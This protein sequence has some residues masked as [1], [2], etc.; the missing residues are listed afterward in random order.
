MRT[1]LSDNVFSE[2]CAGSYDQLDDPYRRTTG[3]RPHDNGRYGMYA[4]GGNYHRL[5]PAG[6]N[7]AAGVAGPSREGG[8]PPPPS[9]GECTPR[10]P[11]T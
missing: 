10:Y 4:G 8:H 3:L 1:A 9:V 7:A 2:Y 5:G 6:A 11:V